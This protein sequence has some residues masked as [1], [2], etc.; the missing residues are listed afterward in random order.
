M[1]ILILVGI[2]ILATAGGIGTY[3]ALKDPEKLSIDLA[4]RQGVVAEKA[5]VSWTRAKSQ[6]NRRANHTTRFGQRAE[7]GKEPG[8][9]P[10]SRTAL[11]GGRAATRKDS[12]Y[13]S[14]KG[15]AAERGGVS[16]SG[17][18]R[19]D[20]RSNASE[21]RFE[22]G[23]VLVANAP[24]D[25]EQAVFSLGFRVDERFQLPR[26]GMRV[27]GLRTPS[28]MSV[29]AAIRLLRRQFPSVTIDANHLYE[30]AGGPNF[31]ESYARMLIGWPKAPAECGA[32]VRLGMI[33]AGVAPDHPALAGASIDYRSFHQDGRSP[34]PAEHGTAVAAMMVGAPRSGEGWGGLLPGAQLTVANIFQFNKNGELSA[35]ARGLLKAIDFMAE[36]GVH[37]VN[38]SIAGSDN[39]VVRRAVQ[40]AREMGLLLVAAAGNWGSAT[41][42]AYPAAY[43]EV[44]AVTAVDANREI[45]KFANRGEYIDFAAPGV[46]VWTAV[47]GGGRFQ[48]GTSFASPYISVLAGISIARGHEN[49]PDAVRKV[50]RSKI[51]DLGVPGRDD[52]FGWGLIGA[53]P[54][55][56]VRPKTELRG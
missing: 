54:S 30:L 51:V 13:R 12:L 44:I 36:K 32:G 45:Y 9:N 46:R 43:K 16:P 50:L 41:R 47:P 19:A 56:T 33:D 55:C 31:P 48:S 40:K 23:E 5:R 34:G 28:Q 6:S 15:R 14:A 29:P 4:S 3:V 7:S 35:S 53:Q 10:G 21:E 24:P 22:P 25:L 8:E 18:S 42:P 1:R 11:A 37:V 17:H 27:I 26:L 49:Q 52:T 39:D 38:M 2:A 20:T